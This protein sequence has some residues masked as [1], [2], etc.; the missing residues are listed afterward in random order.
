MEASGPP[1]F[2]GNPCVHA[3]VSDPGEPS[4]QTLQAMPALGAPVL[5]SAVYKAS[6]T[7]ISKIS[8]L[9]PTACTLA[10]YAS[11]SRL[12]VYCLTTTQDSL[13]A[14]GPTLSGRGFHPLG[15]IVK[16]Q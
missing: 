14:G 8:G 9:Y 11:R 1:R 5:P 2:L 10:V 13:P 15:S 16:F 6:A 7:T 12:P 3:L 4:R